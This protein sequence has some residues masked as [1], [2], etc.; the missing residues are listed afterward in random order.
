MNIEPM[1]RT[2]YAMFYIIN[3]IISAVLFFFVLRINPYLLIFLEIVVNALFMRCAAGRLK[4]LNIDPRWAVATICIPFI[5][6][7]LC[8]PESKLNKRIS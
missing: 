8:F 7:V 2:K 3:C 5:C 4:D 6:F 1:N